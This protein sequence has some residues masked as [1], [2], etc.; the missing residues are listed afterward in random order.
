MKSRILIPSTSVINFLTKAFLT[1][2]STGKTT[3]SEETLEPQSVRSN[4]N[5]QKG[6]LRR[7]LLEERERKA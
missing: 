7:A 1:A 4:K 3:V 6:S 5:E 2:Y